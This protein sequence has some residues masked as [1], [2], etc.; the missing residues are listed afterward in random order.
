M[1]WWSVLTIKLPLVKLFLA[2]DKTNW[3]EPFLDIIRKSFV[4]TYT[5]QYELYHVPVL[6][7]QFYSRYTN[8]GT[9]WYTNLGTT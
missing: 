9:T 7:V 3:A 8:L 1:S 4:I 2:F 6:K 5:P